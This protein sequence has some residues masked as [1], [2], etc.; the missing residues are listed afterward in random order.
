M[1]KRALAL[2]PAA[3]FTLLLFSQT[4]Q[5]PAFEVASVKPVAS[6]GAPLRKG[7]GGATDP[8]LFVAHNRT[9][10]MLV[11]QAYV[12]PD[13]QIAG[14]P[15]WISEDRFDIDARPSEAATQEQ[16]L[17]MLR[18][19]L[20]DRFQLRTHRQTRP[21]EAYVLAV[22]KG[23]PKLGPQFHAVDR[24]GLNASLDNPDSKLG[25][26]MGGDMKSFANLVRM[27][28]RTTH[29]ADWSFGNDPPPILDQT[30]LTGFY[31]IFIQHPGY[32]GDFAAAI[33][34]QLGLKLTLKKVPVEVLV[35]DSAAHP[36]GN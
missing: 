17:A 33:E 29:P 18:T 2:I 8:T 32:Q 30:G 25:M 21:I 26:P 3:G 16:K 15:A 23:G 28:M 1:L 5:G 4:P 6:T 14:G 7:A 27:N 10:K 35:I 19:L 22:P 24:A 11:Q 9:V 20:T 34:S 31:A 36:T 12:L 13:Y